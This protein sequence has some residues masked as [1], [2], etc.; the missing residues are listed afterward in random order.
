MQK[1][2]EKDP[3]SS[4]LPD[5]V[6]ESVKK[7]A[8]AIVQF[9]PGHQRGRVE[10]IITDIMRRQISGDGH[11]EFDLVK[12]ALFLEGTATCPIP[13]VEK[14]Y[15]LNKGTGRYNKVFYRA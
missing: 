2:V 7:G 6:L 5:G 3:Y 15:V 11:K 14:I 12:L 10:G 8:Q 13:D 9:M 4:V 1:F